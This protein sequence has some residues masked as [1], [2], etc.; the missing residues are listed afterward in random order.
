MNNF[1]KTLAFISLL[2]IISTS[3]PFAQADRPYESIKTK[4]GVLKSLEISGK[5]CLLLNNKVI[6]KSQVERYVTI[7]KYFEN[8]N[9]LLIND[10]PRGSECAGKYR[11]V[12]L[13]DDGSVSISKEIG[14]C[15][16]PEVIDQKNKILVKFPAWALPGE[17]WIYENGRITKI[18]QEY[19]VTPGVWQTSMGEKLGYIELGI[20][21]KHG[22][23]HQ[24][25]SY[26]AWFIVKGPDGIL[27]KTKKIVKGSTFGT[28][29][30]PPDFNHNL[31]KLKSGIYSWNCVVEGGE[32]GDG[33]FQYGGSE[34]PGIFKALDD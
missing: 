6:Y 18:G 4:Q 2:L 29:Q 19:A 33:R 24:G 27:F 22:D 28:V 21:D 5:G 14:N 26:E 3:A 25:P 20:R 17:T 9:V 13:K 32:V 1:L 30:F 15:N 23:A 34:R 10:G 11:F 31:D 7:E 16:L 8:H 12:T